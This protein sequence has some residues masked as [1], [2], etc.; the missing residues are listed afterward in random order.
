MADKISNLLIS[1]KALT[2]A[3]AHEL[4]T[5]IFRIQWQAEL[6]ADSVKDKEIQQKIESITLLCESRTT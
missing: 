1:N 2:N 3:I 6:L 5:P 4:R